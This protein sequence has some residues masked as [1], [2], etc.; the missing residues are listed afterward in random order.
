LT[1]CKAT[2]SLDP[3]TYEKAKNTYDSV[4]GKVNQLLEESL[5]MERVNDVEILE[6]E[7]AKLEE[8]IK[9]QREVVSEEKAELESLN[10]E[11]NAVNSKI[12]RLQ[13]EKEEREEEFE[14]FMRIFSQKTDDWHKPDD[15]K[16]YWAEKLDKDKEDLWEIATEK[17]G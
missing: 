17:R 10:E 7:K 11:L 2:L 12:E 14:R 1:K 13:K 5:D 3:H 9:E 15:I 16:D 6:K 4:S 8:E